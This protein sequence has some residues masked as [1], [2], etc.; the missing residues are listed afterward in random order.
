MTERGFGFGFGFPV[1]GRVF[2]SSEIS[3]PMIST[4]HPEIDYR[5]LLPVDRPTV[6]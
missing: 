6:S 4:N 1:G 5:S 2:I 3:R